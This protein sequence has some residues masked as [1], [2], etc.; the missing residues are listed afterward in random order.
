[1]FG[2]KPLCIAIII[3]QK[4]MPVKNWSDHLTRFFAQPILVWSDQKFVP[5]YKA[6]KAGGYI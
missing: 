6:K 1:M 3:G 5:T 2:C 4:T